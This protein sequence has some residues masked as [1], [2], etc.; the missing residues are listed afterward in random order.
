MP[1]DQGTPPSEL[2]EEGKE[3]LI[4][5]VEDA[6]RTTFDDSVYQASDFPGFVADTN[7]V[8]P[9]ANVN[10]QVAR[11][12]CR[13]YARGG[14]PTNLPGFDAVWGGIC[15]PYLESIGEDPV[16][17]GG[18]SSPFGGGQCPGV[19]Y[20]INWSWSAGNFNSGP[21]E[22]ERV[23]P[24]SYSREG[25]G[26]LDCGPGGQ[27]YNVLELRDGT[28]QSPVSIYAGCGASLNSLTVTRVD[29]QSDGC[30]NPA[31][32][33]DPPKVRPGLP[34]VP[35]TPIDIPG[36]GPIGVNI[37][38]NPDG[39]INVGLPDVGVD[40]DIPVDFG[41]PS[42]GGEDG[43]G[44]GGPPVPAPGDD[45]VPGMGQT[46]GNGQDAQGEAP[47]GSVLV[48]LKMNMTTIPAKANQYIPGAYRGAAYIYMGGNAGLDQDFAGSVLAQGQ[49]VYAEKDNL[50]K[51]K[52]RANN[53]FVF[54]VVPYYRSV[55]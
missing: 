3:S 47:P 41:G 50:T 42:S 8:G 23:G 11:L 49:F 45:G 31:P 25:T 22:V 40:I 18:V 9:F 4:G 10:R 34:I 19:L 28:G 15:G 6:V 26:S 37:D 21:R 5:F 2:T 39:T 27:T 55:E 13:S 36:I 48:G 24:L 44:G 32:E 17:G 29:G 33:Y 46:A 38:F 43:P 12:A 35:T 54:N 16:P 20:R 14:G 1:V 53:D 52:V 7:P 51:W 30:G